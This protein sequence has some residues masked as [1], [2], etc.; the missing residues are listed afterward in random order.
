MI[1]CLNKC[2]Y[3][4]GQISN[5][6]SQDCITCLTDM[7]SQMQDNSNPLAACGLDDSIMS[8]LSP[9]SGTSDPSVVDSTSASADSTTTTTTKSGSLVGKSS[10]LAVGVIAALLTVM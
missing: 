2:D 8:E 3:N 7:M 10:L 4:D 1:N 9:Q 6:P 5:N